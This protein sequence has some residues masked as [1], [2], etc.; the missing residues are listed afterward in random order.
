[1]RFGGHQTFAIR[2][3]WLYKGLQLTKKRPELFSDPDLADWL[4][5]GKNM[6]K[7]IRH[8]LLATGLAE[9]AIDAEG[10]KILQP[11]TLGNLI[12]DKDR[13]IDEQRAG[14]ADTLTLTTGKTSAVF[15]QHGVIPSRLP[16]DKIVCVGCF[17]C[18][19]NVLH[20]RIRAS[21]SY[22]VA[23]TGTK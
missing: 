12:W 6:A 22:V 18:V 20:F 7:A 17:C 23:D 11:T 1:M 13:R 10:K 15:P 21:I 19:D 8:W 4:G 2:D 16:H 9:P 5:V 3:G 14:N